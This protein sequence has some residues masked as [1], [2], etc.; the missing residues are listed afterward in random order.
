MARL[1]FDDGDDDGAVRAPRW[2]DLVRVGPSSRQGRMIN[3]H[4]ACMLFHIEPFFLPMDIKHTPCPCW[5]FVLGRYKLCGHTP[6]HRDIT[7]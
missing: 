6:R 1:E 5:F 4:A 3:V 7:S 2:S